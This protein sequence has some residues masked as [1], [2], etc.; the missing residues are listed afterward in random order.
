MAY[1]PIANY[2]IIGDLDTV[3]LIS[4]KGSIDFFCYPD[5]DSPTI[6]AALLD[7]EKG[8]EFTISPVHDHIEYKQ[9]YMPDTNVLLTRFLGRGSVG[10]VLDF[11]P[12][13]K[14]DLGKKLMRRVVT[15]RGEIT[16]EM[17]CSPRF[18]YGRENHKVTRTAKGLLFSPET[19]AQKAF[20]LISDIPLSIDENAGTARFTLK[21]GQ[22]ATFILHCSGENVKSSEIE[23][24]CSSTLV[25]VINYWRNWIEMCSYQGRWREIVNRSAL[26]LKLLTSQ[27]YGS[28]VAAPTF[29]LPELVGGERNWDYRYTWIRDSAFSM[30]A[31]LRLGYTKE[32]SEFINWIENQCLDISRGSHLHLMYTIDG[33]RNIEEFSLNHFKGYNNTKPV[34]IG[35]KASNQFQ[36]DIYGELM[37]CVYLFDHYAE[38]IS[39]NFWL[40]LSQHLDWLCDNWQ[41][42]DHSIW[43]VRAGRQE[44]LFSRVMCWVAFDRALKLAN[45]RSF[46]VNPR[47][48]K[49]RDNIFLDIHTNFF[50]EKTQAFVQYKGGFAVDASALMMPI[51]KFI[52]PKDPKWLSTLQRI[53]KELV[54]DSLVYRYSTQKA[55]PDGMT[56]VEG[57][58]SM[59][60]FWYVECLAMAGELQKARFYFEKMLGFANHL[61][62]YSEQLGL[63]GEHL[64]NF[65]QAFSHLGLISAAFKLNRL[66]NDFR[67]KDTSYRSKSNLFS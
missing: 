46:P 55:A 56:G 10:E 25:K 40:K 12:V 35:N 41:E 31:F 13:V 34:R 50:D 60:T 42:K 26:V 48:R 24:F 54:S 33:L 63:Q 53:E 36:L 38:P 64:G 5:F 57:S 37:N 66:L 30:Y 58:F 15:V 19:D 45:A 14:M 7:D 1:Q 20:T 39:Y 16:Y 51:V 2:G 44:F 9:M 47:W 23:H 4:A 6:F 18:N 11:M 61:G 27:K 65:P 67:N 8:G 29:G 32:A 21:G 3:A 17:R 52:S 43:E 62:L 59:C 22:S 49:E 28:M